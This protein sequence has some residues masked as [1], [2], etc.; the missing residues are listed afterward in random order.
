MKISLDKLFQKKIEASEVNLP[1]DVWKTI[2]TKLRKRR[3]V[4]LFWLVFG[5]SFVI[6]ISSML[7]FS[8]SKKSCQ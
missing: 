6:L 4:R 1:S 2:V 5:I 3:Q 7:I 8:P